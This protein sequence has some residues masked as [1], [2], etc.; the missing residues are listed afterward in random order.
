M[1]RARNAIAVII[2]TIALVFTGVSS[3]LAATPE[4]VDFYL[5]GPNVM[6]TFTSGAVVETFDAFNVG[7]CPSTWPTVGSISVSGSG[8]GCR[9]KNADAFGGASTGAGS[10]AVTRPSG[11]GSRYVSVE[12]NSTVT[13]NLAH[14][15]TYLGFWWSAG[16]ARNSVKLYSGGTAGRLVGTFSTASIV[17][18]LNGGVGTIRALDGST[19]ATCDYY[20]NPVRTTATCGGGREPFAYVHLIASGGLSFDTVVFSQGASGGFE[21]DNMAIARFVTPDE[22][23]VSF[24]P[25][26]RPGSA[27]QT[28]TTCS[29]FTSSLDWTASNFA[30]APTYTI[31]P[32][33]PAD[34]TFSPESGEFAGTPQSTLA[35]TAFTVTATAGSQVKQSTFTLAVTGSTPCPSP[36]NPYLV[37]SNTPLLADSCGDYTSGL[38]WIANDFSA[39]PTYAV[40]PRLP[41]G[42]TFNST[43]GEFSGTPT[44]ALPATT[45]TVTATNGSES[46]T[47]TFVFTVDL[48]SCAPPKPIP[49]NIPD[50]LPN[51]GLTPGALPWIALGFVIAGVATVTATRNLRRRGPRPGGPANS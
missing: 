17:S 11:S 37:A 19:Y 16:D 46:A 30:S 48:T 23:L 8:A 27:T 1:N 5:S 3:A 39:A 25:E 33:L 47:G 12:P 36:A 35:Q 44:Q 43:T 10:A 21:F 40:S 2:A 7:A 38:D 45:Y 28:A 41:T 32:S 9:I 49:D 24:P 14:A 31:S 34:F 26:L 15:E 42:F 18:M 20:G 22:S 6:N 29:P 13:L 51:T 4:T 50:I